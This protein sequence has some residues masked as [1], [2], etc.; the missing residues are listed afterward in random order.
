MLIKMDQDLF[1]VLEVSHVTPGNLRG[2]VRVNSRGR[3]PPSAITIGSRTRVIIRAL[4]V[5]KLAMAPA[6]M[7]A[8]STMPG[9]RARKDRSNAELY[10]E[11]VFL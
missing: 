6:I 10:R 2:F 1:R 5:S 8:T 11:N 3:Y 9:L 7:S 4:N